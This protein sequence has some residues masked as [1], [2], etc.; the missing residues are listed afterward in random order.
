MTTGTGLSMTAGDLARMI[1]AEL[2]G[3]AG[4]VLSG[5]EPLDH[6]GPADLSFVR[7][8]RYASSADS[9]RAGALLVTRGVELPSGVSTPVLVVDDADAALILILSAVREH[10]F[11]APDVGVHPGASVDP[12]AEVHVSASVGVGAVIE[13]SVRIGAET[14][15]GAGAVVHA[16]SVIGARCEIGSNAVIGYEG[17]GFIADEA[18]GERR[19]LPHVGGVR[20]GDDVEIGA[21]SCVDR[22]KLRDTVIGNGCKIDNLVQ[23]GHNCVL[24]EHVVICG[25]T[26]LS[27]SVTIGD[28]SVLAG[29]V[30]VA[31]GVSIGADVTVMAKAGVSNDLAAG[32]AYLGAPAQPRAQAAREMMA[33]RRLA[34]ASRKHTDGSRAAGGEG[35]R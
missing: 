15:I 32:E 3:D 24:G 14:R 35:G 31:D 27:G 7:S 19:R 10:R 23:I 34:K 1:G 20:I 17:F 30:G 16:G 13:R 6:A 33:V 11:G 5:I 26:G 9:S 22:G 4:V 2:R 28:R 12:G 29:Q 21:N 18:T 25:H 8:S